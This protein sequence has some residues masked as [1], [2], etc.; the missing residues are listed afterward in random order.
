M[1]HF[2]HFPVPVYNNNKNLNT[3]AVTKQ[4]LPK[5]QTE[6]IPST[7]LIRL[8]EKETESCL[9]NQTH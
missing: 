3:Q 4:E 9:P 1:E 5:K 6:K 2:V 8:K 7:K